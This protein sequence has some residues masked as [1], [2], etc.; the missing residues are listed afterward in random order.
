MHKLLVLYPPPLSGEAFR[1]HYE[2]R[3]LPLVARLPG[4]LS[5]WHSFHV[6][7]VTG[8]AP[9]FCIWEGTFESAL[10]LQQA[11]ESEIGAEVAAD[12][13]NYAT[14]GV[15]LLHMPAQFAG[16]RHD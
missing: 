7:S 16:T 13:A 8:P 1:T 5:S 9:Y 3:H 15:V 6:H 14:G 2:T 11:M 10:A 12:T 4:L